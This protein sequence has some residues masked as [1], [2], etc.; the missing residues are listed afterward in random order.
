MGGDAGR[1]TRPLVTARRQH[2]HVQT[3]SA[4]LTNWFSRPQVRKLL[5]GHFLVALGP[6]G[7]G[8]SADRFK[9]L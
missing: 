7:M 1:M 6:S 9:M 3:G 8:S 4:A 5:L 2:A